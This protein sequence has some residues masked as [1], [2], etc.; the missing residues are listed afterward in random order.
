MTPKRR[1]RLWPDWPQT[2]QQVTRAGMAFMAALLLVA[3]AA[4]LS[5]NNL[6]FLILAAMFSTLLISG[7]VSRLGLAGL[8]LDLLLPEH[9]PARRTVRGGIR[10]KNLKRWA[11]SFS[12]HVAGE[13]ESS[14]DSIVYFPAISGGATI[15][16]SVNLFFPRRGSQ[17]E[18]NFQF[19]TTFPFGFT[20][21]R[22]TVT[23]RHDIVIYP[24]LDPQPGFE[25]LLD[26]VRGEI[27]AI[28]RGRGHDFYRIRP[29]EALE[30]ARHVDWKATAHTGS[31]QVREFARD[32]DWRVVI[33]LDLDVPS[34]GESPWFEK[35]VECCAFLAFHLAEQGAHVRLRTQELDITAP[36]QANIH[37]ILR[38]LALVSPLQGRQPAG[39]DDS[40]SYRIVFSTNPERMAALGWRGEEGCGSR[41][42]GADAFERFEAGESQPR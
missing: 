7:L 12:I 6:L 27:E 1:K 8:E 22:E 40:A 21:R 42:L 29:Y 9:I 26:S 15:E 41:L 18:R 5:A 35:A 31:L 28:Q 24:C 14:I 19:S 33:Y 39:P 25:T 38:Y 4:F 13:G 3:I 32:E 10:V 34:F 2:H 30:S 16:E 20:E 36:E 37:A 11:P 17:H 23:T